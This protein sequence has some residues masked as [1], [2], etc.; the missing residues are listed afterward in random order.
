MCLI[1]LRHGQNGNHCDRTG[2]SLHSACTFIH[3]RKVCIQIAGIPTTTR[4]LLLRRRNLTQRLCIVCNIR[5][6]NQNVHILLKCQIFR[7]GQCHFRRTDTLYRRVICKVYKDNRTVNRTCLLEVIDKKLRILKGDTDCRENYRKFRIRTT[8]LC[9]SCNL[10]RQ[11]CVRQT[12]CRE[13]RQLLPTNQCI[14]PVNRGHTG[15]DKFRR[16]FTRRRVDGCAVDVQSFFGNDSRAAV[17]G[18]AHTIKYTSQNI[19]GNTKV[20]AFAKETNLAFRQVDTCCTFKQLYQSRVAVYL[21]NLAF[22][23]LAVCQLD[24]AQLIIGNAFYTGNHHQR[25]G[26][27]LNRTIFLYHNSS[28]PFLIN[29]ATSVL[30]SLSISS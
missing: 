5:Q 24:F 25:A 2:V 14:Q 9:L 22:S 3:R 8:N 30:I 4:N 18:V 19:R 17:N 12:G 29:S 27:F 7:C 6:N 13:D 15:L 26:Y 28:A 20:Q 23:D 1:L 10:N 21:Q 11:I 16:I